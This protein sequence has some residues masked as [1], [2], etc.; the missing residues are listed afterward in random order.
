M[1]IPT[2]GQQLATNKDASRKR[3]FRHKK[4]CNTWKDKF[5][6]DRY[7][8]KSDAAC[9]HR[10][11]F[12]GM[13]I[14]VFDRHCTQAFKLYQE[15]HSNW[16]ADLVQTIEWDDGFGCKY[17]TAV[18]NI[19]QQGDFRPE[20]SL[21]DIRRTDPSDNVLNEATV[22][23]LQNEMN[24]NF[25]EVFDNIDTNPV[26]T[27]IGIIGYGI[28]DRALHHQGYPAPGKASPPEGFALFNMEKECDMSIE[29]NPGDKPTDISPGNC[30]MFQHNCTPTD[31]GHTRNDLQKRG[32]Y[33]L[34]IQYAG[35]Y[36]PGTTQNSEISLLAQ[37]RPP[38]MSGTC[39]IPPQVCT[40]PTAWQ[41]LLDVV[42]LHL[43]GCHPITSRE[44]L[45]GAFTAFYPCNAISAD[46]LN[47]LLD[48]GWGWLL[49]SRNFVQDRLHTDT[50]KRSYGQIN[51]TSRFECSSPNASDYGP[52]SSGNASSDCAAVNADFTATGDDMDS[53][54]SDNI[55]ILGAFHASNTSSSEVQHGH[56]YTN[57][58]QTGHA[59]LPSNDGRFACSGPNTGPASISDARAVHVYCRDQRTVGVMDSNLGT[60]T[61][62]RTTEVQNCLFKFP[63]P[64]NYGLSEAQI[65]SLESGLSNSFL[66]PPLDGGHTYSLVDGHNF[67]G[68][69]PEISKLQI[70]DRL[71]TDIASPEKHGDLN[72]SL[73]DFFH[74]W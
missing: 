8:V 34:R 71:G 23:N 51:G 31:K 46:A 1:E 65:S 56:E 30:I 32:Y 49:L 45:K 53:C 48:M 17:Q 63:L 25:C 47:D 13:C 74:L 4:K 2:T 61:R 35:N 72:G 38:S 42:N 68:P 14:K 62:C 57:R 66:S 24:M 5:L 22:Q 16:M 20:T 70:Q 43:S 10:N 33:R 36:M 64:P 37:D 11:P 18:V 15:P 69:F 60:F 19:G 26:V 59:S 6:Q 28:F 44:Q 58:L 27:E 9:F 67:L 50:S 54:D 73:V 41:A 55:N 7:V 52:P 12:L 29:I 21:Y 40:E 39:N 3:A